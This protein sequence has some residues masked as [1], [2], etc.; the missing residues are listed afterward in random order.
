MGLVLAALS[1]PDRSPLP[2][3]LGLAGA[4]WFAVMMGVL[5]GVG[6]WVR[7][8]IL[9]SAAAIGLLWIARRK[10]MPKVRLPHLVVG[11]GIP[12]ALCLVVWI[13][14][15]KGR[16]GFIAQMVLTPTCTP[17]RAPCRVILERRHDKE[18]ADRRHPRGGNPCRGSGRK[19]GR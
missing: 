5:A 2:L 1:D 17:L 15:I 16:G 6:A 4:G 10:G 12:I 11:A 14:S 3:A 9:L 18:D 7:P 19:P 8:Q 13:H